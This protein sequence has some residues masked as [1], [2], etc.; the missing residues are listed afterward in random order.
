MRDDAKT[1]ALYRAHRG[2]LVNYA[3][4]IVHDRAQAEDV[5][6]EAY[7]RFDAAAG[8]RF[9]DEPVGYLFRIVRNLALDGRRSRLRELRLLSGQ[10]EAAIAQAPADQPSPESQ[11]LAKDQLRIVEAALAELPE[12]TRLALEMHRLGGYKLRDIAAE[13][14]IS[15][16]TAHELVAQGVAHCRRRLRQRP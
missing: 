12:R 13:L 11:L 5:V 8:G 3:D 1:V 16:T 14:G 9:L 7:L 15:V 10:D 6:Q 2:E 4:G